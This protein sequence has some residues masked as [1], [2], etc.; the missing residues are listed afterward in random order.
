[1]EG[2][3]L[4]ALRRMLDY[5]K[6]DSRLLSIDVLATEYADWIS[7]TNDVS[8]QLTSKVGLLCSSMFQSIAGQGL[9]NDFVTEFRLLLWTTTLFYQTITVN[10]HISD[11]ATHTAVLRNLVFIINTCG[12]SVVCRLNTLCLPGTI[13]NMCRSDQKRL[14]LL[15]LGICLSV[16]YLVEESD[17]YLVSLAPLE[18]VI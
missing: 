10:K 2:V 5:I 3:S 12:K 16:T 18:E 7:N 13:N 6:I 9:G 1:V 8:N 14:F 17:N 11:T 4:E 15:I